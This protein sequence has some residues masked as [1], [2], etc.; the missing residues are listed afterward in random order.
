MPRNDRWASRAGVGA[1]SSVEWTVDSMAAIEDFL[2]AIR[3][4][5]IDDWLNQFVLKG[6]GR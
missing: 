6:A 3:V 5:S 1:K 4:T 2:A